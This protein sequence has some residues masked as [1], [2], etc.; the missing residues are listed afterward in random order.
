MNHLKSQKITSNIIVALC[1]LFFTAFSQAGNIEIRYEKFV[2]DNG[3][4]VIIHEDH[5]RRL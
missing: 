2:I 3:L 4:T 5:K 1:Y